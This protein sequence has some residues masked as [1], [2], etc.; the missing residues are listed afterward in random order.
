MVDGYAQ[1]LQRRIINVAIVVD[2]TA[3]EVDVLLGHK[4]HD[5]ATLNHLHA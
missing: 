5:L 4:F 3:S 1:E 2:D